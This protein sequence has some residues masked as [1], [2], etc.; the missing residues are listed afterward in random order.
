MLSDVLLSTFVSVGSVIAKEMLKR[1]RREV[2]AWRRYRLQSCV[3][4]R[5]PGAWAFINPTTLSRTLRERS[6]PLSK[7]G[8]TTDMRERMF[9][10]LMMSNR[11]LEASR[12]G[13]K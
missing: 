13:S 2:S 8:S 3:A 7:N 6:F 11:K 1:S 9:T 5:C 12:E 10:E 4:H